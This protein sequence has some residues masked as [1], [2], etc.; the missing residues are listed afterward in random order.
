MYNLGTLAISPFGLDQI[1]RFSIAQLTIEI[2]SFIHFQQGSGFE[3]KV[4]ERVIQPS[5][6]DV[7]KSMT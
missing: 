5:D 7:I 3:V 6:V 2:G 1:V 4:C